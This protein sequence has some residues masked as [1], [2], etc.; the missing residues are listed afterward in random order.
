MNGRTIGRCRREVKSRVHI[1]ATLL[2]HNGNNHASSNS[3]TA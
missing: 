1:A 2:P 3:G